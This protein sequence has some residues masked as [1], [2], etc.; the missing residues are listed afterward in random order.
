MSPELLRGAKVDTR[1]D[2]YALGLIL[3]EMLAGRPAFAAGDVRQLACMHLVA[4]IPP[5]ARRASSPVSCSR[6]G[7]LA[8]A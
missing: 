3:Y 8:K 4:P 2:L 5:L 1:S 7:A 6:A